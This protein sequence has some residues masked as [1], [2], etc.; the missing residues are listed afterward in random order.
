[1]SYQ[2]S[3]RS[4]LASEVAASTGKNEQGLFRN[5]WN[6]RIALTAPTMPSRELR[7]WFRTVSLDSSVVASH[8]YIE[9]A[10][11][12]FYKLLRGLRTQQL[13][14]TIQLHA[15]EQRAAAA[16]GTRPVVKVFVKHLHDEVG[17][18]LKS[19]SRDFEFG[20]RALSS[21]GGRACNKSE[22]LHTDNRGQDTAGVA[23]RAAGNAEERRAN[24]RYCRRKG[25]VR[26]RRHCCV[27]S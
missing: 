27:C 11:D 2:K 20:E 22:Q 10:R 19:Y 1:M 13:A 14:A 23:Y 26:D 16:P 15:A 8:D 17:M 21:H 18:R 6:A 7:E 12:A 4:K 3:E 24:R 9:R 25:H 5:L